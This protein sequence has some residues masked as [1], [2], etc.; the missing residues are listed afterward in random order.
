MKPYKRTRVIPRYL[1]L[2]ILFIFFTFICLY[3]LFFTSDS[4][5]YK[6]EIFHTRTQLRCHKILWVF[7]T[8]TSNP[9]AK[10]HFLLFCLIIGLRAKMV[11]FE[12]CGAFHFFVARERNKLIMAQSKEYNFGSD[13]LL[14]IN[15]F[16]KKKKGGGNNIFSNSIILLL[17]FFFLNK[18]I[19]I[20]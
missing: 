15:K 9:Q 2:L 13:L 4:L 14:N 16:F 10:F 7:E 11:V 5:Y 8:E 1:T 3:L 12:L 17:F 19:K 6:D 18:F 20:K